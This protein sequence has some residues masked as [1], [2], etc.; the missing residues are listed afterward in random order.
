MYIRKGFHLL[1]L[2]TGPVTED[3]KGS[4]A[5]YCNWAKSN[6]TCFN[7][8]GYECVI[9]NNGSVVQMHNVSGPS[10]NFTGLSPQTTYNISISAVDGEAM[11][12]SPKEMQFTTLCK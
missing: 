3:V 4:N 6:E 2:P 1:E 8:T 5:I 7:I 11:K 10:V 12:S 9:K